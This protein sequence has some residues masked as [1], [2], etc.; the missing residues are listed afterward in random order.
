MNKIKKERKKE[1]KGYQK[2][3]RKIE[4]VGEKG[5]KQA[6]QVYGYLNRTSMSW[7]PTETNTIT[8]LACS[9]RRFDKK[10]VSHIKMSA[11]IKLG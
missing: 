10:I 11:I 2:R 8:S 4:R 1:R 6:C 3:K 7:L 9:M 5:E